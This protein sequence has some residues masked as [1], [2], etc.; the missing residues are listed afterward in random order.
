M[1]RSEASDLGRALRNLGEHG[2][3]LALMI[4]TPEQLDEV[5]RDL[6]KARRLLLAARAAFGP[7]GC[8]LHPAGPVDPAAGDRCLLCAQH[9]RAG[10]IT[11]Q[12]SA[13]EEASLAVICAV[14]AE[15]GQEAA[16]ARFGPRAVARAVLHCRKAAA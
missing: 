16:E 1:N 6:D 8:R 4:A 13:I 2:D 14:I 7:T 11:A 12:A 5:L 3:R 10:R 15:E 9:E